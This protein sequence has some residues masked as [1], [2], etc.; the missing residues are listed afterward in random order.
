[1]FDKILMSPAVKRIVIISN[2]D[3]IYELPHELPHNLGLRTL[4][5]LTF[6]RIIARCSI[7]LQKFKFC[8]YWQ[9][10]FQ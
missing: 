8:P 7:L 9:K 1:M 6:H 4:G 10:V 5:K 2:R 3:R